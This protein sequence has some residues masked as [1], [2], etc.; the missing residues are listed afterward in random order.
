VRR[1]G[2]L[3]TFI[4]QLSWNLEASTSW[5]PQG[6]S[7]PVMGLLFVYIHI[8]CTHNVT[9]AR[10][11]VSVCITVL[12]QSAWWWWMGEVETSCQTM[13]CVCLYTSIHIMYLIYIVQCQSLQIRFVCHDQLPQKS[14]P[15]RF[16]CPFFNLLKPTGHVMHHQ[17]NR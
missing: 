14:N 13:C 10:Y 2:N 5:N 15:R 11:T 16:Q 17:F 3:T 7:R 1:A 9:T 12:V 6:L 4:C 8:C